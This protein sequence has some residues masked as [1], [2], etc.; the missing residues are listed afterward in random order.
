[1][2]EATYRTSAH[3]PRKGIK[4]VRPKTA[5][6]WKLAVKRRV[7]VTNAAIMK[8]QENVTREH[9][10]K[11]LGFS[12]TSGLSNVESPEYTNN[13]KPYKAYLYAVHFKVPADWLY[14]GDHSRLEVELWEAILDINGGR[15]GLD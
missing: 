10:A 7:A 12:S 14:N 8:V 5:T 3:S 15:E 9:I 4:R 11:T 13:L 2:S 1:M 6:Q